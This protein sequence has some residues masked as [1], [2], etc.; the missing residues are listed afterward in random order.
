MI[1]SCMSKHTADSQEITAAWTMNMETAMAVRLHIETAMFVSRHIEKAY[2]ST[3]LH[4][5]M[6]LMYWKNEVAWGL[7]IMILEA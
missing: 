6:A 3:H 1:D 5:S 4:G 2:A 7:S